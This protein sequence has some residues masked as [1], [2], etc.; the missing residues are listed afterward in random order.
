MHE[1]SAVVQLCMLGLS[2]VAAGYSI[3]I[4]ERPLVK[5]SGVDLSS[6]WNSCWLVF[7]T[8]TT[9]G[10]GDYYPSTFPGRLLGFVVCVS[11]VILVSFT[12]VFLEKQ[13]RLKPPEVRNFKILKKLKEKSKLE[14]KAASLIG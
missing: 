7:V 10:Y 8:M 4:V 5:F 9:V 12:V 3:S 1:S 6:M 13:M 2:V 11:G 14:V